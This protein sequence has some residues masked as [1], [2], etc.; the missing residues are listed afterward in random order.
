MRFFTSR[1]ISIALATLLGSAV[2]SPAIA[3]DA[4]SASGAAAGKAFGNANKGVPADATKNANP[5]TLVPGYGGDNPSQTGL[6][7]GGKQTDLQGIGS[8][9]VTACADQT[10]PN[11]QAVNTMVQSPVQRPNFNIKPDDPIIGNRDNIIK[12][13]AAIAG[14]LVSTYETCQEVTITKPAEVENMTCNEYSVLE[15]KACLIGQAIQVDPD[16][17]YKC[18]QTVQSN[19]YRQCTIGRV[20][21]IDT[22]YNYKCNDTQSVINTYTCKRTLNAS[23]TSGGTGCDSGGVIPTATESDMKFTWSQAPLGYYYLDWGTIGDNYWTGPSATGKIYDR[24]LKVTVADKSKLEAFIFES[25]QF[26]DWLA[27]WV[28]NSLVWVGPTPRTGGKNN[29]TNWDRLELGASALASA[30]TYQYCYQEG[31]QYRCNNNGGGGGTTYPLAQCI[32]TANSGGESQLCNQ[33]KCGS[34]IGPN[35]NYIR[36]GPTAAQSGPPELNTNWQESLWIDIKS[37]IVTGVNTFKLRV[38]VGDEGEG[39]VRFTTRQYCPTN[40]T[41][42]WVNNCAALEARSH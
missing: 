3:A 26:D 25:A 4:T 7:Q 28:N 37:K 10:D 2:L 6:F 17:I 8:A 27:L 15:D 12:D 30:T 34:S 9:A 22:D 31:S 39:S 18:Q 32:C 33:Y 1:V 11:C 36:F 24:T 14:D 35:M 13:P 38:I 16:F 20:I 21:K 41:N 5:A 42:S 19:A 40:C 29:P 23:C